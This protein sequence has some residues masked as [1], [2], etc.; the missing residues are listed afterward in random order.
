MYVL[1][2][3]VVLVVALLNNRKLYLGSVFFF[4]TCYNENGDNMKDDLDKIEKLLL[5]YIKIIINEYGV[6]ID[7]DI[8]NHVLNSN[9]VTFSNS[10]TIS[11]IVKKGVLY[12]PKQIYSLIP[13]FQKNI[14]YGTLPN[15]R[16]LYGY[17]YYI[18]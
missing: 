15:D 4:C 10:D 9:I 18:L 3:N 1:M 16:R 2:C 11:F 5:R 14:C 13:E 17:F 7:S 12:L 8:I 6:Y